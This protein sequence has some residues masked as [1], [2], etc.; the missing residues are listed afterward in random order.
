MIFR[1]FLL[2]LLSLIKDKG[3]PYQDLFLALDLV[4]DLG[5]ILF[6]FLDLDLNL[7]QDPC[8]D[9]DLDQV[10]DPDHQCLGNIV[11]EHGSKEPSITEINVGSLP[12][13]VSIAA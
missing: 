12:L 9:P 8:L 7:L 2:L 5:P 10:P 6:L 1:I 13:C 11:K 3:G 4:Q